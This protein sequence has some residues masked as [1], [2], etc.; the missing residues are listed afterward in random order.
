MVG[1]G[2]PRR[3]EDEITLSAVQRLAATLDRDPTT[4]HRGSEMPE[5]WYAILFGSIAP[6]SALGPD[7]HLETR[8][9]LPPLHA[10]RR[11][12]CGKRTHFIRPLTIGEML[13][14]DST[15][16]RREPT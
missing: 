12:L 2:V 10:S 15:P 8:D 6:E 5:S 7:G 3:D 11:M 14:R 16:T 1:L 13:P 4:F 9:F